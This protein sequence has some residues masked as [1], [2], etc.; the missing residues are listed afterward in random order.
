[1]VVLVDLY[2]EMR[3]PQKTPADFLAASVLAWGSCTE[4]QASFVYTLYDSIVKSRRERAW[5]RTFT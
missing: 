5:D 2:L 3:C 4:H 1:V